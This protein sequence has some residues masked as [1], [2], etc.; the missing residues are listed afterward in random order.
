MYEP[1][2]KPT[3]LF[4]TPN[5]SGVTASAH[6]DYSLETLAETVQYNE[7][8]CELM[9]PWLGMNVL[10]LGTGIGNL[11]PFFLREN[12]KLLAIDIDADLVRRHK[13][14]IPTHP[15]LT[16]EC[17]SLQDV[18]RRPSSIGSFDSIVSSNVLE[19]IP[20]GIDREVIH[21]MHILLKEGG[22][23]VHWVPASNAIYG[24]IDKSFGHHRRYSRSLATT[25]FAAHGFRVL[26]CE[27]WNM[28]G[29]FAW[30]FRGRILR[31][32]SLGK[33]ST[34]AFDRYVVPIL[35][36]VEPLFPRP[37]GQSLLIVA[38]KA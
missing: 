31:R 33:T 32:R 8:I 5:N 4:S 27:Y 21:A 20:D 28:P 34:L 23:A 24:S 17:I 36:R 13:E 25:L 7:W 18:A 14:R 1:T 30:W 26:R 29:F 22:H 37:F 3:S 9:Q 12:R 11:T 19:H 16:V 10:E 38:Q 6:E 15:N 2:H 35:K